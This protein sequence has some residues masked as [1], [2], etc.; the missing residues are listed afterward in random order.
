MDASTGPVTAYA[1]HEPPGFTPSCVHWGPYL[2][3]LAKLTSVAEYVNVAPRRPPC[4]QPALRTGTRREIRAP[5]RLPKELGAN[6]V[7][8]TAPD[9]EKRPSDR[10]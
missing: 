8:V 1:R 3:A 4:T 5:Q 10:I 9:A 7:S 6:S 2:H